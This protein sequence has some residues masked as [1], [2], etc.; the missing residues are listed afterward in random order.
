GVQT[1][2]LPILQVTGDAGVPGFPALVDEGTHAVLRVFADRGQAEA[3]HPRGVDR[4]LRIALADKARQARK[5]L[6][7]SPKLGLLYA[8][9][10]QFG[11]SPQDKAQEKEQ[12]RADLVEA[13]LNAVLADGLGEIREDRKSTRLNS[14]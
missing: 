1:C 11:G 14:S 5:Q 2:A 7:V 12:L 9:I 8:A 3:A 10:E 13:A 6:P 4:L